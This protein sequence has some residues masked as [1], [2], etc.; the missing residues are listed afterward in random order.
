M[1]Y[2]AGGVG[3][4]VRCATEWRRL[5]STLQFGV[6]WMWKKAEGGFQQRKMPCLS[7]TASLKP[8]VPPAGQNVN[9]NVSS[10]EKVTTLTCVNLMLAT[11]GLLVIGTYDR[12]RIII[13]CLWLDP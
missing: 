9:V 12:S 4:T 2:H 6:G 13:V 3:V 10:L 11:T 1:L 5:R 7:L 8:C